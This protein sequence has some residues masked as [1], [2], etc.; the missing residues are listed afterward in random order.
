[1]KVFPL[2][3]FVNDIVLMMEKHSNFQNDYCLSS[4]FCN[5]LYIVIYGYMSTCSGK[6]VFENTH[7][8]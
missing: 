2:N 8:N 1:M 4:L 6:T 7:E 5:L 3:V